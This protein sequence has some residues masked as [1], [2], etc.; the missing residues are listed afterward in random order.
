MRAL[1]PNS[2]AAWVRCKG[3]RAPL[4]VQLAVAWCSAPGY[5]ER[6]VQPIRV[7]AFGGSL[8][9]GSFNHALVRIAAEGARAAGGEVTVLELR[10]VAMPIFDEDLEREQGVPPGARRFKELLKGHE[11]LLVASPE[12]N[13]SITGVLKNALDWASRAEPG[14]KPYACFAGKVGGVMSAS[15]GPLGAARSLAITRTLLAQLQVL[16]VPEQLSVSR[17]HEAF[18]ERG[19]LRDAKQQASAQRIGARVVEL[20]A[21]LRA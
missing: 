13:G 12:Y 9:R 7:L 16:V 19:A 8:R 18:D 11:A 10:E 20:A 14:E 6:M 15:P 5:T 1:R 17:A 3:R 21:K 4:V 2:C